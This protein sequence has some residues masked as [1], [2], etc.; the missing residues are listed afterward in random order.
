MSVNGVAQ[1][2]Q[3]AGTHSGFVTTMRV[4]EAGDKLFP[5]KAELFQYEATY[6]FDGTQPHNIPTAFLKGQ[7]TVR[8]V[9]WNC[10]DSQSDITRIR[11]H[12]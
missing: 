9:F 2:A 1:A 5:K 7:L 3:V 8:G 12:R 6:Q 10:Q 11:H 4:A